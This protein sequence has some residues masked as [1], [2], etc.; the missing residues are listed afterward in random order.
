MA[1]E[2]EVTYLYDEPGSDGLNYSIGRLVAVQDRGARTKTRYDIRGRVTEVKRSVNNPDGSPNEQWFSKPTEYD[3]A[4]RPTLEGTGATVEEASVTTRYTRRGAVDKVD[5]GDKDM[6][7]S[8]KR[9]ADG[10]VTEI[11]YGAGLQTTTG[12]DYDDL[13]RLRNLTTYRAQPSDKMLLQRTEVI[14]R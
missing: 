11:T 12:F 10:L 7:S 1:D 6:V 9:D 4:D 2:L 5:T 8:V 13:R 3:A 14:A